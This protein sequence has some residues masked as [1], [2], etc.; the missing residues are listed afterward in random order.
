MTAHS[1]HLPGVGTIAR[2]LPVSGGYTPAD[3]FRA[4]LTSGETVFVKRAV[5]DDTARWLRIEARVYGALADAPF[6]ARCLAFEDGPRPTL[7]LEDL[8]HAHWPGGWRPGDVDRVR[9][10]LRTIAATAA[11]DWVPVRKS[12]A[13]NGW[14][15]VADDPA[16]FLSLGLCTPTWLNTHLPVLLDAERPWPEPFVLAHCDTR[17]DNLCLLPDRVVI[18]DWNWVCRAPVGFD[19]AF[20]SASLAA[21]GGAL[22]E[23]VA[24]SDPLWAAR[25]S[26]FFAARAGLPDL[27]FAPRVRT[28]QRIQLEAALPW[29]VR[30]LGLPPPEA[31]ER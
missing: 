21:E 4:E 9:D 16:P 5:N 15:Q 6:L 1:N 23:E 8:A 28:I 18:V 10:T 12:E 30:V 26:G 29:A 17:S 13:M 27:P 19:A 24:G 20:W 25:V 14:W 31:L 3:R 7:V 22:P 11:P 2:R